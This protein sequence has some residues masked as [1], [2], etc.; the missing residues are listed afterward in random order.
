MNLPN[1]NDSCKTEQTRRKNPGDTQPTADHATAVDLSSSVNRTVN[2]SLF[3][4]SDDRI[5]RN[6]H[7]TQYHKYRTTQR[8]PITTNQFVTVFPHLTESCLRNS[9]QD[10]G[11]MSS[12]NWLTLPAGGSPSPRGSCGDFQPHESSHLPRAR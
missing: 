9:D 1:Q 3:R 12:T 8:F 7:P 6:P 10:R 11:P 2:S 5:G 4:E